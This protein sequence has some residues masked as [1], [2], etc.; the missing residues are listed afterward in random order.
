MSDTYLPVPVDVAR[1][2]S[3]RFEKSIVVI[4]SFDEAHQLTHTTT[5]GKRA[6]DKIVAAEWGEKFTEASGADLSSKT[7]YED[8][9]ADP[10]EL[11]AARYREATELLQL[12]SSAG[13]LRP[14]QRQR[15]RD[16]LE[17]IRKK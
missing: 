2:I 1:E 7:N 14:S 11:M 5:Y 4:I 3:N 15:V 8:F 17:S 10:D 16:F 12:V 9:R 6:A 13:K